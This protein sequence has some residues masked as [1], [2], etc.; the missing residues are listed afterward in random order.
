VGVD[1]PIASGTKAEA[2]VSVDAQTGCGSQERKLLMT[3]YMKRPPIETLNVRV[4]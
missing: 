3:D 1:V 2:S 4:T